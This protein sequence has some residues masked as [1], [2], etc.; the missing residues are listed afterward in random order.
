MDATPA[1]VYAL[2]RTCR[3]CGE[4]FEITPEEQAFFHRRAAENPAGERGT[5]WYWPN[6]C[7][8]C[9]RLGR[10]VRH[11]DPVDPDAR[12]EWIECCDCGQAF[13]FGGRDRAY[14]AAQNFTPP[15]RCRLCRQAKRARAGM[16]TNFDHIWRG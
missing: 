8:E 4:R 14:F 3:A 11:N 5:G 2:V 10:Q 13:I 9:R 1:N 15:K 7:S 6:R 12:D 16:T